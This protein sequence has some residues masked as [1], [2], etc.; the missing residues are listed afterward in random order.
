MLDGMNVSEN[1]WKACQ[2]IDQSAKQEPPPH[3]PNGY[4]H[5]THGPGRMPASAQVPYS[6]S[7]TDLAVSSLIRNP[8]R[9]VLV[10][11]LP[12]AS[13]SAFVS[14]FRLFLETFSFGF[15]GVFACAVL[16]LSC[17]LLWS[18]CSDCSARID[19]F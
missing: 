4:T 18:F 3:R 19:G 11:L 2:M 12:D 16:W 8:L 10:F 13:S 14:V 6:L 9:F 1:D 15:G 17:L 5:G 7:F